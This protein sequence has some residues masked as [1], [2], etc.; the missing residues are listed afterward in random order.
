MAA[1]MATNPAKGNLHPGFLL[2][3]GEV[4]LSTTSG[5][6]WMKPDARMT[7]AAEALMIKNMSF[8]LK[9]KQHV[10]RDERRDPLAQ[11]WKADTN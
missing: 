6:I 7:P 11:N 5:S 9:N 3:D 2:G 4:K 1:S 10:L 8:P